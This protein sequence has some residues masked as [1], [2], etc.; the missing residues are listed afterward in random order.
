MINGKVVAGKTLRSEY[1]KYYIKEHEGKSTDK[2]FKK[3]F[4]IPDFSDKKVEVM[5]SILAGIHGAK[6]KWGSGAYDG[7]DFSAF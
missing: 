3:V 4:K 7:W 5:D 1:Q 6:K 2:P